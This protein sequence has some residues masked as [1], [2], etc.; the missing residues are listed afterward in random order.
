MVDALV[1][2]R[3]LSC[4]LEAGR[5]LN[6]VGQRYEAI[7]KAFVKRTQRAAYGVGVAA[8]LTS[9]PLQ[10]LR[11]RTFLLVQKVP[12]LG[13]SAGLLGAGYHPADQP[14]LQPTQP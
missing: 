4:A 1:L 10:W 6:S 7:R 9:K 2:V 8:E 11:N 5:D 13:R 3:L 12:L 14:Y